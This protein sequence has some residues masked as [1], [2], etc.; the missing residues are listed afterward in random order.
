MNIPL[1]SKLRLSGPKLNEDGRLKLMIAI[2]TL[3]SICT[4]EEKTTS[5]NII[6]SFDNEIVFDGIINN[7]KELKWYP[8]FCAKYNEL[9]KERFKIWLNML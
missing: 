8:D 4:K 2:D 1:L 7:F 9:S 6:C 5:I 3:H